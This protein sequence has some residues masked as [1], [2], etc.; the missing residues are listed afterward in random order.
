MTNFE[1]DLEEMKMRS[2]KQ[3]SNLM[4]LSCFLSCVFYSASYP[5]VYAETIKA[6]T[7]N[8]ISF[9]QIFSCLGVALFGMLWNKFGDRFFNHYRLILLAETVADAFLFAHVLITG[10][11]KFYFVLNVIIYSVI[12]KNLSCG[13]VKMR[14]KVNPT[15]KER[16]R[17]DNNQNTCSA[18]AS[19]LGAAIAIVTQP[20]LQTLF[21]LALIGGVVDN[22]FYF[23]IYECIR[24]RPEDYTK[25]KKSHQE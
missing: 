21:I 18:I 17:Y 10:D 23:Y 6:V 22:F 13:G 11:L 1:M 12:T 15:D 16:E 7:H 8:Y 4:L 2:N 14:A 3:L 25:V 19:L 5:Y 9:E 20:S 24:K